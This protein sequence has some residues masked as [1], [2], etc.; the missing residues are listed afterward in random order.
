[1]CFIVSFFFC[2]PFFTLEKKK[3]KMLLPRK[4]GS[5]ASRKICWV[6]FFFFNSFYLTAHISFPEVSKSAKSFR[7]WVSFSDW[8]LLS[9]CTGLPQIKSFTIWSN[10]YLKLN[11]LWTPSLSADRAGVSFLG[12]PLARDSTFTSGRFLAV[13]SVILAVTKFMKIKKTFTFYK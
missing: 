1:M 5:N 8:T 2:F 3:K 12:F 9:K 7:I 4:N 10:S 11:R 13:F 6:F